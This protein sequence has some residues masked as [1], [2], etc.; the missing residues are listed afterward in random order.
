MC[1]SDLYVPGIINTIRNII[2]THI[3]P[4]LCNKLYLRYIHNIA[5]KTY[6]NALEEDVLSLLYLITNN[7]K[8][9][10]KNL[11]KYQINKVYN[12][13]SFYDISIDI[14]S[15]LLTVSIDDNSDSIAIIFMKDFFEKMQ[16]QLSAPIKQHFE[17]T[18][19]QAMAELKKQK[20]LEIGRAHV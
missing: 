20:E 10:S 9:I 19:H 13:D 5:K 16:L 8:E 18:I 4:P 7:S 3:I 11:P 1:S 6:P 2:K 17:Q 12:I 15:K 14:D